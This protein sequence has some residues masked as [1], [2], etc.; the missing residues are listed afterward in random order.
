MNE[1]FLSGSVGAAWWDE[2]FFTASTVRAALTG[3]SGD[4]TVRI[5]SGGGLAT[6]GVA[7]F[8]LLSEYAGKKTIRIDG[9]AAS[10]A[11]LIAMAGDEIIMPSGALM[12]IHDP[13]QPYTTGRGTEAD[14][15]ELAEQLQVAS[16]AYAG[17]Y[18]KRS[19]ISIEDARAVMAAETLL[20]GEAAV[21]MGFAT[22]IDAGSLAATAATF[23]YRHYRNAP[24][25]LREA[26]ERLGVMR[27]QE[28]ILAIMAGVP[29]EE[30]TEA[31]DNPSEIAVEEPLAVIEEAAAEAPVARA[32]TIRERTRVKRI[33]DTVAL[34]GLPMEMAHKAIEDGSSADAVLDLVFQQRKENAEMNAPQ[35]TRAPA[36]ITAD[37][38]DKF[39]EGAA[40]A[41]MQKVG[42]KGERNEFS[43]LSLSEMARES[44]VLM[45][46]R[47]SMLDR[48][49][50]VGRAFTMAG[51]HTTSDFANVLSSVAGKAAL[52]GWDE[53][54]E[55]YQAWTR[56]GVLTDFKATKRVGAGLFGTLPA[57]PEGAEYSYGTVGD[58]GEPITLATY[59]KLISFSRQAIINDDLNILG[60][61]PRKMGNAARRTVGGLVTAVLTGNPNMSDSV[62][63]FHATHNNLAGSAGALAVATLSAARAAMRVQKES[64]GGDV[65]NITP[66]YLIV[67]AALEATA[68]QLLTSMVDP[69]SNKG[70]ATNPV[71][72]MAEL[73]VDGRLD[74]SSTTAF[75]LVA[76]PNAFDT[77]EVA[78]LDGNDAPY[79]EQQTAWTSDG[80]EMKVRIDAGVAPL[81]F[82]TFYKNAGA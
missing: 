42:L 36:Q 39:R 59:G 73:I 76:D 67:P 63:L 12:L 51:N 25:A 81:D 65:L 64:T 24:R 55:T 34:A 32:D 49:E 48:R 11:S 52:M 6:E 10:A 71:S 61:V 68:R 16:K 18:A 46:E 20:D 13:A 3:M 82:R 47:V 58:R 35:Q 28:A 62:A 33:L 77:I 21:M 27:S 15:R 5:N 31:M 14:H 56:K 4:I 78:F 70:H 74:A 60:S 45:G 80:V 23:D 1:L 50:M 26:S 40:L 41:L 22:S 9:I 53:A 2:D 29:G 72:G 66:K 79:L 44:L 38:R 7:I 69:Q 8:Q 19:G 75:Y 43:S 17:I 54:A 57:V 37:A 30:R